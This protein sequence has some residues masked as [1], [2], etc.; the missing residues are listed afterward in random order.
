LTRISL[1]AERATIAPVLRL[2]SMRFERIF[3]LFLSIFH[4]Q[5]APRA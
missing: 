1:R 2:L 3:M 4:S 5:D